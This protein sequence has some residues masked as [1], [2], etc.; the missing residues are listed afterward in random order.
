MSTQGV[1]LIDIMA[2]GFIIL[3]LHLIRRKYLNIG[4]ALIWLIAVVGF[5]LL[6]TLT[7]IR[8][9]VTVAVGAIYPAS[10]ISLLA[11]VFIFIILIYFSVQISILSNRQVELIQTI[12]MMELFQQENESQ[13]LVQ[14]GNRSNISSEG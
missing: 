14:V 6:V 7:P 13:L 2:F 10:A 8:D 9:L 12:A 5:M 4:F 11:F 3:I 1:I